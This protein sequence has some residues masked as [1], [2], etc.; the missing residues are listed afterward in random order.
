MPVED[1]YL[2]EM[3]SVFCH[4]G[5]DV[6]HSP[7]DWVGLYKVQIFY[8]N[9][10][11]AGFYCFAYW[12]PVLTTPLSFQEDF[13]SLDDYLCYVYVSTTPFWAEQSMNQSSQNRNTLK[14]TFPDTAARLPG[15]YQVVYVTNSPVS[16]LG[17]SA[18]FQV[19]FC[20]HTILYINLTFVWVET[21]FYFYKSLFVQIYSP[22][23][24]NFDW[25]QSWPHHCQYIKILPAVRAVF[26]CLSLY[27]V[28]SRLFY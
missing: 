3:N 28:C 25:A 26:L 13:S 10:L 16:V 8:L 11:S 6:K 23:Q 17:I 4:I 7:W 19:S 15:K 14:L 20:L 9:P 12:L 2:D 21:S 1:W 27:C 22:R 18:P 24:P 5:D